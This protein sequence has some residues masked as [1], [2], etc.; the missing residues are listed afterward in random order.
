[1]LSMQ[2]HIDGTFNSPIPGGVKRIKPAF[3]GDYTGPGGTWEDGAPAEEIQLTRV[4]IQAASAKTMELFVNLGGTA[5]PQDVRLVHI[6][7]G[8]NYLYPDDNGQF[9]DLLEFSDGI[10]VR[11]WRVRHCDNR[12]WR[13]FCKA[14]VERYRGD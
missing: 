7:D 13:S 11:Q 4:N 1:M 5:N 14:I 3:G 9:A 2:D 8:V 6:N 10:A 12:P